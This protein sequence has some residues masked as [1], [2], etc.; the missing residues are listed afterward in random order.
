MRHPQKQ[1]IMFKKRKRKC[2]F[3]FFTNRYLVMF[4]F[5]GYRALRG[6]YIRKTIS[7]MVLSL[8]FFFFI[9][10]FFPVYLFENPW[11][12][13]GC[14]ADIF[15]FIAP[16]VGD[17]GRTS[18][19]FEK[20]KERNGRSFHSKEL[21]S[22]LHGAARQTLKYLSFLYKW[23]LSIVGPRWHFFLALRSLV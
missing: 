9:W 1:K 20:K 5:F 21:I 17:G 2:V 11:N 18:A 6:V 15:F 19:I 4:T 16:I 23:F 14:S 12:G 22:R 7:W 13:V 8:F 3:F 10:Y